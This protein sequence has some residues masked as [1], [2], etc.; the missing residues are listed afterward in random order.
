[1]HLS[2]ILLEI[3]DMHSFPEFQGSGLDIVHDVHTEIIFES[4]SIYIYNYQHD[5]VTPA[6][7]VRFF[8]STVQSYLRALCVFASGIHTDVTSL[9][10][11]QQELVVIGS[12]SDP[13]GYV[14]RGSPA[15]IFYRMLAVRLDKVGT[16]WMQLRLCRTHVRDT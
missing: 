16:L 10:R 1:M 8:V 5:K 3:L 4:M 14:F 12:L 2:E 15:P 6:S 9:S 13:I 7:N 11:E